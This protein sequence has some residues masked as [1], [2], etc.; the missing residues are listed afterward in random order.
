MEITLDE[1]YQFGLGLFETIAVEQGVPLLLSAHLER[2]HDSMRYFQ[3]HQTVREEEI[4]TYLARHDGAHHGLKLMVS[5]ENVVMTLRENPYT[6]AR[7]A[8]GFTLDYSPVYRNETSCL[9]YHKTM[10]YGDC[11]LEKRRARSLGVDELVF[12][13]SRG[14]LCEGTTTNLFFVRSG[15]LYTPP[16]S[17]G[18]LPGVMR[19]YVMEHFPVRE[20]VLFLEDVPTME[21]CF[22]TN[23]LLG[24]MPVVSLGDVFFFQH[25]VTAQ[26]EAQWRHDRNAAVQRGR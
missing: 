23:S 2:L 19:R 9:T 16:V 26:C 15:V 3:L 14:E 1:G 6:P 12:R 18:L 20:R 22:V 25:T 5:Q 24:I 8:K 7:Y 4:F 10:N 21:E 11:I 17:C 13:N